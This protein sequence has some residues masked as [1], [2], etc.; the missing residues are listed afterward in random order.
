MRTKSW[1][2]LPIDEISVAR[3]V[4]SF[5]KTVRP[6]LAGEAIVRVLLI[7]SNN[8]T[9]GLETP[10]P[11][12]LACVAAAT[13]K[14]GH[15]VRVLALAPEATWEA[16]VQNTISQ[17]DPEVIGISVRN[18]DDQNMQ[19]AHFFLA[20]LKQLLAV[21]RKVSRAPVVLGGA[22]ARNGMTVRTTNLPGCR[23][24]NNRS[25]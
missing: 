9:S 2:S 16:A 21:C 20:P 5:A 10:L 6:G 7:S 17:L 14:A 24:T 4:Q 8:I 22:G 1:E 19:C 13:E 25:C 23:L 12:G 15:E 18:I 3:F 11:L